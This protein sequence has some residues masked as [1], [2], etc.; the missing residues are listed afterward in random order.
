M[1]T[2]TANGQWFLSGFICVHLWLKVLVPAEDEPEFH[3][4]FIRG[5][6]L[7]PGS[8]RIAFVVLRR[9]SQR[10]QDVLLFDFE[11]ER[12]VGL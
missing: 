9:R 5:E 2:D 10:G 7:L 8:L 6:L 3:G 12:Q 1:N 11:F 4:C